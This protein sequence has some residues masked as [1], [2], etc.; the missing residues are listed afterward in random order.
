MWSAAACRR[1]R[2]SRLA[3]TCSSNAANAPDRAR[4]ASLE[5]SGSKLPHSTQTKVS[6]AGN[7]RIARVRRR[8]V[9][10]KMPRGCGRY[11][12]N[13]ECGGLPPLLAVPACRD[14]LLERGERFGSSEA[15]LARKQWEQAPALHMESGLVRGERAN[16]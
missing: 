16:R 6:F 10:R 9:R 2:P 5:N 13:V 11:E 15:S 1:C 3:G 12:R 14:V 7:V 8:R 4:Q